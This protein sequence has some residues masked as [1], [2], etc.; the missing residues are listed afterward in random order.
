MTF[1][2]NWELSQT[3]RTMRNFSAERRYFT[4][5]DKHA[6]EIILKLCSQ[7][8]T[9]HK[10][11]KTN[12]HSTELPISSQIYYIRNLKNFKIMYSMVKLLTNG[13][14]LK[15]SPLENFQIVL[16]K[17]YHVHPFGIFCIYMRCKV[18]LLI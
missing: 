1:Q 13:K 17:F 14:Y 9:K 10:Q 11:T 4:K 3:I 8:K 18:A 16:P 6:S 12:A 2:R 15:H 5:Y 7:N